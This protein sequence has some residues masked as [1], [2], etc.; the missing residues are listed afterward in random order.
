MRIKLLFELKGGLHCVFIKVIQ[1]QR[2][3]T[4]REGF[5]NGI[6]S[7]I[8]GL[9]WIRNRFNTYDEVYHW[10]TPSSDLGFNEGKRRFP[11]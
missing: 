6:N 3:L 10:T 9:L 4:S 1:N 11:P 7:D 5:G 2:D 8:A